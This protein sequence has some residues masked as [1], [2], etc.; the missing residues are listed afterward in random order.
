MVR[1]LLDGI[2]QDFR[3]ALGNKLAGVYVH[4]SIAF[5]C[6][7]WETSD[8]DFLAVVDAPLS[9]NEKVALIRSMLARTPDAPPKGFEMSVVLS[10]VCQ[11]I[12]YPT[13]FELHFSNAYLEQ[14]QQDIEGLCSVMLGADPDLAGHFAVTRA[15]GIAWYGRPIEEVFAPVPRE[16]LMASVMNDVE[17][18]RDMLMSNPPYFV[19]NLCRTI[20]CKEEVL[21]L[22]KAGGAEWALKNLPAEHRAVIQSALNA[23]TKG[24]RMNLG[25]AEAFRDYALGR[26]KE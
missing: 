13:P 11:N 4:G 20:A 9:L 22:S 6:F 18:S 3:N 5:G 24:E 1:A 10:D 19:L 15:V 16:T 25:G 23:Y 12:V 26:L 2:V 21:M 17:D 7:R 8:V 14:Y